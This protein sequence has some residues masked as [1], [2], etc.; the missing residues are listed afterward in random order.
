MAYNKLWAGRAKDITYVSALLKADIVDLA[1]LRTMHA[2][3][4]L[5]AADRNRVDDALNRLAV[6]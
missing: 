2:S 6:A 5:D 3:N 1:K 4:T